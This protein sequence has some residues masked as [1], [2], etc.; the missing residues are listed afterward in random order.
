MK[1]KLKY[2]KMYKNKTPEMA[3][4][5]LLKMQSKK[6]KNSTICRAFISGQMY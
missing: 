6:Y 4:F 2:K 3:F 1:C 5:I